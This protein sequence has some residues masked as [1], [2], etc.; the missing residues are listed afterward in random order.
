MGYKFGMRSQFVITGQSTRT[1]PFYVL[2]AIAEAFVFIM[3]SSSLV[4]V[5]AF[6]LIPSKSRFYNT[7]R[8]EEVNIDIVNA[9]LAAQTAIAALS[10]RGLD[11]NADGVITQAEFAELFVASN[12]NITAEQANEMASHILK[13]A[14]RNQ[15]GNISFTEFA[16]CIAEDPKSL[17]LMYKNVARPKFEASSG[18]AAKRLEHP[19]EKWEERFTA[20][21]KKY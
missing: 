11:S 6:Y 3:I 20:E 8:S 17:D 10:F 15:Q 9:R 2:S 1:D 16:K 7:R 19:S 12:P 13:V 21:G 18:R 14:D 5:V 4:A